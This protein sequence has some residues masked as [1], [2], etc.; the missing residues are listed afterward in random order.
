MR[1]IWQ[2]FS[3]CDGFHAFSLVYLSP[4]SPEQNLIEI[5]WRQ[6][7]YYWLRW[8]AY[9]SFDRLCKEV[10]LL[11]RDYGTERTINFA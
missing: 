3:R 11:L 10:Q 8:G 4:Y 9:L 7:K 2:T 6:V 5:L 1:P